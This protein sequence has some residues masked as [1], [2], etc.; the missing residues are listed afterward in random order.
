MS[1]KKPRAPMRDEQ[2]R[3]ARAIAMRC[4]E[5]VRRSPFLQSMI[6]YAGDEEAELSARQ[7]DV[8]AV[9]WREN[10]GEVLEGGCILYQFPMRRQR[11]NVTRL[12]SP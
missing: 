8:L 1:A 11:S 3:M 6:E 2:R 7:G 4:P 5:L 10:V 12:E 9:I